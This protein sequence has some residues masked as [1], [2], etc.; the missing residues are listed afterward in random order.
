MATFKLVRVTG[1]WVAIRLFLWVSTAEKIKDQRDLVI[2]GV[3]S[4]DIEVY[5]E[6]VRDFNNEEDYKY[7]LQNL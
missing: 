4:M 7:I 2:K 3:V 1:S 5:L 6:D